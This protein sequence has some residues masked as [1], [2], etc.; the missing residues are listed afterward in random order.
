[1]TRAPRNRV[2][3]LSAAACL[4]LAAPAASLTGRVEGRIVNGTTGAAGRAEVV[5]LVSLEEGMKPLAAVENVSDTF[6]FLDVEGE[7]GSRFLVQTQFAGVNYNKAF[8]FDESGVNLVEVTVYDTTSLWDDVRITKYQIGLAAETELLRVFKIFEIEVGGTPPRAVIGD[9]G[10]FR[11]YAQPDHLHMH[12]VSAKFG[13]MP[14]N[15]EP[16]PIEGGT[17]FA[18]NFPLRPG[19]TE[20][21][22]AY[23]VPYREI[24]TVFSEG[25]LYPVEEM[26]VLVVP[27]DLEVTSELLSDRGVDQENGI[28]FFTGRDLPKG[29]P[30]VFRLSGKGI[31]PGEGHGGEG[32]GEGESGA[33]VV[34]V[35]DR[36]GDLLFPTLLGVLGPLLAGVAYALTRRPR[37]VQPGARRAADS[38]ALARREAILERIVALDRRNRD[39]A[40]SEYD[41]WQKREALKGELVALLEE[42][43]RPGGGGSA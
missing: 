37:N 18:I 25:L 33:S 8:G 14:L 7:P 39:G 15:Q 30:V 40:I 34:R 2:A 13:T 21:Q 3:A 6:Q 26:N 1:M 4:L 20:I 17:E 41:Y 32:T 27:T 16:V 5:R 22:A 36:T 31:P 23:D 35:P 29:A 10:A 43:E 42:M 28:R 19:K 12:S 9:P 38:E 24:S 11:F